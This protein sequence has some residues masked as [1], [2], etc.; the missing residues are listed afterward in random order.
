MNGVLCEV[1]ACIDVYT[2]KQTV[3]GH[4]C[5]S[6]QGCHAVGRDSCE[7]VLGRDTNWSTDGCV[8]LFGGSLWSLQWHDGLDGYLCRSRLLLFQIPIST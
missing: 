7:V 6:T 2:R 8:G 5:E 4:D 3:H 1:F